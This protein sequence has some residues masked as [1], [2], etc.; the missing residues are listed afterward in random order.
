MCVTLRKSDIAKHYSLSNA[1]LS[2]LS[3]IDW[4]ICVDSPLCFS[5]HI[6]NI[7]VRAEQSASLLL[8]CF[9]SKNSSVFTKAFIV[10]V[11]SM[12]SIVHLSGHRVLLVILINWN[13]FKGH[14]QRL[15]GMHYLSYADSVKALGIL[16]RLELRRLHAYLIICYKI[17]H[18]LVSIVSIPF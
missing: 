11:C 1:P 15:I 3:C 5:E 7:V 14:S 8:R 16:E 18:S 13:L 17:V 9:L 4:G 12:L 10:Y 2:C 6:N